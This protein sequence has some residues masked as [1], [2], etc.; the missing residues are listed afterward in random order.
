[1]NLVSGRDSCRSETVGSKSELEPMK[2]W[3]RSTVREGP[4]YLREYWIFVGRGFG[5]RDLVM[6]L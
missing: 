3:S 2:P 5:R 4:L 6:S 1:M